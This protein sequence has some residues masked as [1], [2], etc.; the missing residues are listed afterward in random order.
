MTVPA[1]PPWRQG[2]IPSGTHRPH[3]GRG[4]PHLRRPRMCPVAQTEKPGP[5]QRGT[6]VNR[7]CRKD[8]GQ[9]AEQNVRAE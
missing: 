4:E 7:H 6:A 9:Q 1:G 8:E 2:G 3:A 5:N